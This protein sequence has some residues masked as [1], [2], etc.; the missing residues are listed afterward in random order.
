MV[1]QSRPKHMRWLAIGPLRT[2]LVQVFAKGFAIGI[3]DPNDHEVQRSLCESH[4]AHAKPRAIVKTSSQET[5][6]KW[7]NPLTN[8]E[9]GRVQVDLE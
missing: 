1:G 9:C 5:A 2:V 3:G 7:P 6:P 8:D 4:G